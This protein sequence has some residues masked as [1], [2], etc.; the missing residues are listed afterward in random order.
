MTSG[1]H[2]Y[3][4]TCSLYSGTNLFIRPVS[5]IS[6]LPPK[7]QAQFFYT[8]ALPIDDPLSP[9]PALSTSS[10]S[11]SSKV[12]PRPFSVR[13]NAALEEAWQKLQRHGP[14]ESPVK[15]LEKQRLDKDEESEG[16]V[17]EGSKSMSKDRHRYQ[18]VTKS[19]I[20][21]HIVKGL[22]K[23]RAKSPSS[24]RAS[25][26]ASNPKENEKSKLSIFETASQISTGTSGTEEESGTAEATHLLL[27]DDPG[28]VCLDEAIPIQPEELA[29]ARTESFSSR[30]KSKRHRSPFHRKDK[31]GKVEDLNS[32]KLGE[33]SSPPRRSPA[34]TP[35]GSSP[36]EKL[37]TGTPF[38]RAPSRDRGTIPSPPN[39][40][41]SQTDGAT[42]NSEED[43]LGRLLTR[44]MI[45]S[46]RSSS[47]DFDGGPRANSNSPDHSCST[48]HKKTEPQ[49]AYIPVGVSRLHLVELPDLQVCLSPLMTGMDR[50]I[51][52]QLDETHILESRERYLNRHSWNLVQQRHHASS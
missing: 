11:T 12:P 28:H 15:T 30:A 4:E 21:H 1:G 6:D 41:V 29:V 9:L 36:S 39:S 47:R 7:V 37:T 27:C 5:T 44:P 10:S 8:S 25:A 16:K 51:D 22:P 52:C 23:V 31:A 2:S 48:R 20:L 13:D 33:E 34:E 43:R 49:R 24:R 42:A 46:L 18:S 14:A 19:D 45:Y 35:Y 38:L 32:L 26:G 50:L 3:G 17:A 40:T